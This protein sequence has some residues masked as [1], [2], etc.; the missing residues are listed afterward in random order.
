MVSTGW[1]TSRRSHAASSL[2]VAPSSGPMLKPTV[3]AL[4]SWRGGGG[5]K[6]HTHIAVATDP[7]K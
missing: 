4:S 3:E 6:K 2:C 7:K 1:P 5:A